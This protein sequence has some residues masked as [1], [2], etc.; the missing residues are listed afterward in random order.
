MGFHK[1]IDIVLEKFN[2]LEKFDSEEKEIINDLIHS[3]YDLSWG[4]KGAKLYYKIGNV[5]I[6]I[7]DEEIQ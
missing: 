6:T 3:L 4:K 2:V 1:N 5:S 7:D